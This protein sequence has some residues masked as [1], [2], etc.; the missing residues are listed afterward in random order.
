MKRFFSVLSYCTLSLNGLLVAL[1]IFS[2]KLTTTSL[3]QVGGRLHPLLLH[4]PIG[5]FVLFV[6]FILALSHNKAFRKA[7]KLIIHFSAFFIVLTALAGILLS[8]EGGYDEQL[9]NRHLILG[10]TISV[11]TAVLSQFIKYQEHLYFKIYTALSFIILI[12]AAHFGATLTHGNNFLFEPVT[13]QEDTQKDS[14]VFAMAVQPVLQAKCGSC[15]NPSKQK[16]DLVLTLADGIM[17]GGENGAALKAGDPHNSE[18]ISRAL[19]PLDHDDHMPPSGKAQLTDHELTLLQLWIQQGA[20]F[21][22]KFTAQKSTDS[23][24]N[25][26]QVIAAQYAQ[27]T[28]PV[29]YDFAFADDGTV[30]QLNSPFRNVSQISTTEPA[31]KA[32]FFLAQYYQPNSLDELRPVAENIIDLNVSGMPI[33]DEAMGSITKFN[34][35]EHLNLNNTKVTDK[36]INTL[37]KLERLKILKLAGTNVTLVGMKQLAQAKSIQEVYGWNTKLTSPDWAILMKGYPNIKWN[38]GFLA[39]SSERLRLTPPILKNETF[40]LNNNEPILLRHNLPG[41]EIHYT[42]DGSEPD[43]TSTLYNQPIAIQA[44][45]VLKAL[46]TK[47]GWHT[48]NVISNQFFVKGAAP[49]NSKLLSS[50]NKDYKGNGTVSF[51]DNVLGD[52]DNFRDGNWIGFRESDCVASFSFDKPVE[53]LTVVYLQNVGSHIMPPQVIEVYG[54]ENENSLSLIKSISPKQPNGY[55]PNGLGSVTIPL[56]KPTK[57]VKFRTKPVGKL[58]NWHSGKGDK[59]WVMIS[60]IIFR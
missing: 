51:T 58:P 6:F 38:K 11:F 48:S 5:F 34:N 35:L 2:N 1:A 28:A 45:R 43:S 10:T 4:L 22:T 19:L 3:L 59:A 41:T 8:R 20:S 47:S 56:E 54:G 15:H 30:K 60:E 32:D 37:V 52:P 57:W 49:L 55:D 39:E 26:S 16:G 17:K 42:L 21:E 25:F 13:K 36:A 29:Q 53:E 33:G 24:Q 46:A 12:L 18:I 14:T 7:S 44:H 40:L 27:R 9:L 23:L 31:L 50:P